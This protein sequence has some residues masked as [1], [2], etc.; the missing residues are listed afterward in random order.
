M[1][2]TIPFLNYFKRKPVK[3]HSFVAP[4]YVEKPSGDRL[5][6][7]VLPFATRAPGPDDS[8]RFG[9][10]QATNESGTSSGATNG[11]F[12]KKGGG[13]PPAVVLAL[14]PTIERA[15]SLDL[16]DVV[17]QMPDGLVRPLQEGDANRRVLLKASEIEKGMASA[18]PTVSISTIYEQVPEIFLLTVPP[19]DSRQLPLPFAKVLEQ[20][21]KLQ[22]RSDQYRD[23]SVPQVETPFLQVTLEDNTR[24][25]TTMEPIQTGDLPPVRVQPATA[26]NLAAAEP[27]P[28]AGE[29]FSL[30]PRSAMAPAP[31]PL[32]RP[33]PPATMAPVPAPPGRARVAFKLTPNGTDAPAPEKVPA[34][35]GPS[36]PTSLPSPLAPTRIPFKGGVSSDEHPAPA[37]P[38]LTKESFGAEG[39]TV[40]E[41]E[42]PTP[43]FHQSASEAAPSQ[44]KISLPLKPILESLPPFQLTGDISGVFDD[45]RLEL[46]FS[47][48]EPQLMTGR[49]T[50]KPE[51]FAAALSEE[52]RGLFSAKDI[53]AAVALPLQDVLKNLPAASLGI[54]ADQENEEK[55]IDFATPFSAKA[56]ED[57][58]RFSGAAAPAP[59]VKPAIATE[60]PTAAAPAEAKKTIAPP[61]E[62]VVPKAMETITL[63]IAEVGTRTSLQEILD[64]DDDLDAKTV[65]LHVQRMAGVKSCALM[66]ADGLSLAGNLPPEFEA[67]GL[68]AMAPMLIQRLETHSVET[69]LGALRAMTLSYTEASVTFFMQGNLCLAAL[70]TQD[71]L[72]ANVRQQMIRIIHELSLKYSRPV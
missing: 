55:G 56:E 33:T 10:G 17:A 46:P 51:E 68:C 72:A 52:Y 4:V 2:M 6:K 67:D 42:T 70:H 23:Q 12:S 57:A 63:P 66:F 53:A 9:N 34:S 65:V 32:P 48:V 31:R 62:S 44:V 3:E 30:G 36:V 14:E 71:E 27:E 22:L 40:P 45:A 50:L 20:F 21:S 37:D 39:V 58:K 61:V 25:G 11:G 26:E 29:K 1:T 15:I 41:I 5:S 49:V 54:R 43:E 64:T 18:R 59:M 28:I 24:F 38:W 69:K 35:S 16:A 8:P 7:T 19:S 60:P 47:L 13:L